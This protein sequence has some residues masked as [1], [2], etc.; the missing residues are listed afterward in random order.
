MRRNAPTYDPATSVTA[1]VKEAFQDIDN[2]DLSKLPAPYSKVTFR[3]AVAV[4]SDTNAV[5]ETSVGV[6][7]RIN[8]RSRF[9]V[10]AERGQPQAASGDVSNL[11][12]EILHATVDLNADWF[13]SMFDAVDGRRFGQTQI[14]C[15]EWAVDRLTHSLVNLVKQLPSIDTQSRDQTPILS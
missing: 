6:I 15:K 1:P 9:V 14:E 8:E 13:E 12:L 11:V 3:S 5:F 7:H 10:H 2:I 4:T